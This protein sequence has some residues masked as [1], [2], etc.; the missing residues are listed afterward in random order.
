M[1]SLISW[2]E[3][4][5]MPCLY[6]KWFGM[7]CPGCGFQRSF[8]LLLKG[9]FSDSFHLY[10]ALIPFL[11][12]NLFLIVHLFFKFR[13]GGTWLMWGYIVLCAIIMCSYFLRMGSSGH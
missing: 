7:D 5:S 8:I 1:N 6:K 11:M 13:K 3:T 12:V 10:P 2:L 9:N 4:H